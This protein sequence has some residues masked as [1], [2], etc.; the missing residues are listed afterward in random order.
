[1]SL[2]KKVIIAALIIIAIGATVGAAFLPP[3]AAISGLAITGLIGIYANNRKKKQEVKDDRKEESAAS[4]PV[5]T[6]TDRITIPATT[7]LHFSYRMEHKETL[8]V[9]TDTVD[10]QIDED[11]IIRKRP[12]VVP[13]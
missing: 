1:M 12:R 3:L 7:H 10:V 6:P 9:V 5:K 11:S 13:I 2:K 4:E 8:G